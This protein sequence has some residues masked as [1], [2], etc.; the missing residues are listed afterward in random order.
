MPQI[1]SM[2]R[3]KV[4]KQLNPRLLL[5]HFR[6]K[7]H[8]ARVAGS[9]H[10][11]LF[12]AQVQKTRPKLQL[13]LIRDL[14]KKDQALGREVLSKILAGKKPL[15][16]KLFSSD[17]LGEA[18]SVHVKEDRRETGAAFRRSISQRHVVS[19]L[20]GTKEVKEYLLLESLHN[21]MSS[22]S[23]YF[24]LPLIV[25]QRQHM[26]ELRLVGNKE[27]TSH[28]VFLNI[29]VDSETTISCTVY[30]DY[31]TIQCNLSTNSAEIEEVL[32][33]N[34]HLLESGLRSLQYNRKVHVRLLPYGEYDG[35]SP[36][37]LKKIDVKM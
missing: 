10:S 8:H 27:S 1:G 18:L 37:S 24:I 4:L 25:G 12:I 6:G 20:S 30:I 32:K 31:E 21:F 33:E 17:N 28:G 16:Q 26:S 19:S 23:F 9:L 5:V 22:D 36:A 14:Q 35:T 3:V 29:E 7:N 15:I 2:L 13:R 11:D 34:M